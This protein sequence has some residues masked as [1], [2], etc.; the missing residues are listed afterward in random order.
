M[1]ILCVRICFKKVL[2]FWFSGYNPQVRLIDFDPS[3][4]LLENENSKMETQDLDS[5]SEDVFLS[6]SLHGGF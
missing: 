3:E 6:G 1:F 5:G 4:F 2:L